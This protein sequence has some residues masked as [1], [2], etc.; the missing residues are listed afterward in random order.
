MKRLVGLS[1]RDSAA[2]FELLQREVTRLENTVRWSW[3]P[4]D[5]AIWD[6]R[7]TQHYGVADYGTHKRLLHR[8]TLAGDVPV[9]V[10]GVPSSVRVG[11]AS[12]FSQV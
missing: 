7:A 8:I 4:G 9:S 1:S 5:V 12:A 6:N 2:V 10:D 3:S 11:D